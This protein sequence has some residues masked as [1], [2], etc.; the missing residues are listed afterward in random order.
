M[1][2]KHIFRSNLKNAKGVGAAGTGTHHW[3][4]QR[5]T[6]IVI[7]ILYLWAINFFVD[8]FREISPRIEI[9][10]KP[11]NFVLLIIFVLTSLW[12]GKL[13]M[14][15][16]I[17]DYIHCTKSRYICLIGL[18]IFTILTMASFVTAMIFYVFG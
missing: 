16:I 7:A 14:E 4:V 6:A 2:A 5:V 11:H 18:K 13:G 17:D 1:L 10:S 8:I 3:F 12:H 9:A 15:V